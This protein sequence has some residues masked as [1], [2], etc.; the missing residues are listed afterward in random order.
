MHY[1]LRS[2][3]SISS[4]CFVSFFYFCIIRVHEYYK[5]VCETRDLYAEHV[6]HHSILAVCVSHNFIA[7]AMHVVWSKS[8]HMHIRLIH[9][10]RKKKKYLIWTGFEPVTAWIINHF[11]CQCIKFLCWSWRS[12]EI[13]W[14]TQCALFHSI[15]E[16]Q[17]NRNDIDVKEL[18]QTRLI[19]SRR[20]RHALYRFE[21]SDHSIEQIS[22][23]YLRLILLWVAIPYKYPL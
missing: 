4:F 6:M 14:N 16:I 8:M 7:C 3:L 10:R 12:E 2:D 18:L 13:L 11:K 22:N 21:L 5:S 9:K 15:I 23:W 17:S 19:H 1:Q 20:N